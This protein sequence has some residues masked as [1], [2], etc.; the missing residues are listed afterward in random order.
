MIINIKKSCL[1]V[2]FYILMVKLAIHNI[3]TLEH[4][5]DFYI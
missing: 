4:H 3:Y 5:Q 1:I 2:G